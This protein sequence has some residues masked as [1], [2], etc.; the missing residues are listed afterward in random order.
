MEVSFGT[1][2]YLLHTML[3]AILALIWKPVI[4]IAR[5]E[6]IAKDPK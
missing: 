6:S 3:K 5:G 4:K 1:K 2:D